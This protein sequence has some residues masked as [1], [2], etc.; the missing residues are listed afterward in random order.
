MP[1]QT[2]DKIGNSTTLTILVLVSHFTLI[3]SNVIL[4]YPTLKKCFGDSKGITY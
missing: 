3:N 4:N 1:N 2:L